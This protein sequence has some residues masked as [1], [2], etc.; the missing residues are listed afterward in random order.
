MTDRTITRRWVQG[1]QQVVLQQIAELCK[2][3]V[4]EPVSFSLHDKAFTIEKKELTGSD[5]ILSIVG[6]LREEPIMEIYLE[7]AR[8]SKSIRVQSDTFFTLLSKLG[9]KV[10]LVD[11]KENN[12]NKNALLL[13]LMVEASPL[14]LTRES[15][16]AE[17][18]QKI[19]QLAKLIQAELPAS[20]SYTELE[21]Q[22]EQ[23]KDIFK[24]VLPYESLHQPKITHLFAWAHETADFL[25]SVHCV[26][27]VSPDT[28]SMELA[29]TYL[30]EICI[31]YGLSLATPRQ[32]FIN[33]KMIQEL[34]NKAPGLIA[35][36]VN[37]ITLGTNP[38]EI[39]NELTSLLWSLNTSNH[40]VIF[41]GSMEQQQ[42][43]FSGGQGANADP[44]FPIVREVPEI[45]LPILAHFAIAT[46]GKDA[47][48]LPEKVQKE[49]TRKV[50]NLLQDNEQNNNS[51]VLRPLARKVVNDWNKGR[52]DINDKEFTENLQRLSLTFSGLSTRP[53][54]IRCPTIQQKYLK[55]LTD[56]S[57]NS[58]FNSHLLAQ[59]KAINELCSRL[60]SEVLTRPP[61]QPIRY[62]SQG[63][64]GTGK[65]ESAVLLAKRLKVPYV[66]IDAA[67]MPDF[68]T[69]ASQL[70][71]SGRGIVMSNQAGRLEQVAK[72]HEGVVVEI[73]DLDHASSSVRSSLADLFLQVLE[74]GEAQS[75]TGSMFSCANIIFAFT[76]NLPD[77][78]DESVRK[79][80]G[81]NN[82][83]TD[84]EVQQRVIAEIKHILSGAFLSRVGTPILFAPLEGEALSA[85]LE[86]TI[87][88]SVW[89][90]ANRMNLPVKKVVVAEQ[91]G[92]TLL[93]SF[94]TGLT[95]FGARALLEFGR[96]LAAKAM[97]RFFEATPVIDSCT[98][99]VTAD[100]SYDKLL[101]TKTENTGE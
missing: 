57:L 68:H 26:A 29:L 83:P 43:I 2:K 11:P 22:Y 49:L 38:Y 63:T 94:T 9:N 14:S 73:S 78:A 23:H 37:R 32:S 58:Y 66:N 5:S 33:A 27:L 10:R 70:L 25:S 71:G 72:H 16:L 74:T 101:I 77:G 4:D 8:S 52:N 30:S 96:V 6:K 85:I 60:A 46:F 15:A 84:S 35:V 34:A 86:E 91:T 53:R 48:G 54:A 67:S 59:E 95:S 80:V 82:T 97:L 87:C 31:E 20:H 21:K 55:I 56:P 61:E 51:R 89:T 69:A 62:C 50:L 39:G 17:E 1:G 64:P 90:A 81:F 12:F 40:P 41:T 88:K 79:A 13:Q 76:M 75:A 100:P 98:L 19:K 92:A 36:P 65:S 42:T 47:G 93:A 44:L 45:S 28:L 3:Y 18:L 24:M 7:I 99:L